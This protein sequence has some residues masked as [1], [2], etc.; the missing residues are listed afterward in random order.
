VE[1]VALQDEG[2]YFRQSRLFL[3]GYFENLHYIHPILDKEEFHARCEDLWFGRSD[4]QS[5]SFIALYYS[6]MSLGALVRVW[7]EDT[8]EGMNRFQW[9][10]KLFH[11]ARLALG[12]MR[13]T[14]DLETVQCLIFMA[15][16]CQNELNPHLAYMYL[17]MAVRAGLSAG[18]NREPISNRKPNSS[19]RP[20]SESKTWW[21]L[22]SLEVE[23]S[24]ALGRPDQRWQ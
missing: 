15:K 18:H 22:Y 17:G 24:F 11:Q 19:G 16:V 1:E 8:V 10:R 6:I 20:S 7:D 12:E 21:G 2:Y 14:N 9:S 4:R 5:R 3:D 13:A 23:M